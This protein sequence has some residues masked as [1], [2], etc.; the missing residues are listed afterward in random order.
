M[1]GI[2]TTQLPAGVPTA[3]P[4]VPV[5]PGLMY[6]RKW[7]GRTADPCIGGNHPTIGFTAK[8]SPRHLGRPST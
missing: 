6:G 2:P 4:V 1:I 5:V 8:R 3:A 7:L